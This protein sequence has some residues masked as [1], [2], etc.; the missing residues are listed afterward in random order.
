MRYRLE[1]EIEVSGNHF[2]RAYCGGVV[3]HLRKCYLGPAA[4]VFTKSEISHST[5]ISQGV[6]TC[7]WNRPTNETAMFFMLG[8][9]NPCGT[10]G[11]RLPTAP[12]ASPAPAP[13]PIAIP[14]V[15]R[16]RED[17]VMSFK[18]TPPRSS[19]RSAPSTICRV[20]G[21]DDG[22]VRDFRIVEGLE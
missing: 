19:T 15:R 17:W 11:H 13:E 7:A 3:E 21:S 12:L 20:F 5:S 9:P 14:T 10:S 6:I 22:A 18:L 4:N 16:C 8:S 2:R 1:L